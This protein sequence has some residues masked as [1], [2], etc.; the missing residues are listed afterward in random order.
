MTHTHTYSADIAQR[1]INYIF[2]YTL[3]TRIIKSIIIEFWH[4][5]CYIY[6][7]TKTHKIYIHTIIIII[8]SLQ[9]AKIIIYWHVLALAIINST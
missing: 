1:V 9:K 2:V 3:L 5:A 8:N 6:I 4:T 7:T